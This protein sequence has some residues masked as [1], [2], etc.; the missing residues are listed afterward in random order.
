MPRQKPSLTEVLRKVATDDPRSIY[1][2]ARDAGV[3][4]PVLYRFIKGDADG[5]LC[6]LHL[7]TAG[8]LAEALGMELTKRRK[9]R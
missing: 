2:L 3:P 6:G 9:R 7:S 4:Y 1:I 5:K 8:K